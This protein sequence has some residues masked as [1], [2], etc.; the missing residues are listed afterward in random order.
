MVNKKI[1]IGALKKA[2]LKALITA[3]LLG[4][5][6]HPVCAYMDTGSTA[7]ENMEK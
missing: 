2:V 5:M 1:R 6:S 4:V 7:W 3:A